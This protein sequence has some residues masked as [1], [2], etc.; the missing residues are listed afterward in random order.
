MPPMQNTSANQPP[1]EI[2]TGHMWPQEKPKQSPVGPIVGAI[3]I[4]ALLVFGGLYFWGA[5]LNKEQNNFENQL[6]FIPPDNSAATN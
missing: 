6:P 3:I 4:I 1:I 5:H 2:D